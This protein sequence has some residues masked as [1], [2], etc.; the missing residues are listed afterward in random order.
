MRFHERLEDRVETDFQEKRFEPR[1][2]PNESIDP[3]W[4]GL[5][6]RVLRIEGEL[7]H[8]ENLLQEYRTTDV[9]LLQHKL[10]AVG[11]ELRDEINALKAM[12]IEAREADQ[13]EIH[14]KLEASVALQEA[15]RAENE[16]F[17][18]YVLDLLKEARASDLSVFQEQLSALEGRRIVATEMVE[19]KIK[20]WR[21][22]DKEALDKQ[23]QEYERRLQVLNG[24]HQRTAHVLANSISRE[25]FQSEKDAIIQS[26]TALDRTLLGMTPRVESDKAHTELALRFETA[27]AAAS[28]VLDTK[29]NVAQGQ[30]ADLKEYVDKTSGRNSGYSAV[31]GWGIAAVTILISIILM[32]NTFLGG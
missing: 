27:V 29:I 28:N 26:I 22:Y 6:E 18:T 14:L 20:V 16:K 12:R 9:Q 7:H 15:H 17:S 8:L 2:P 31:Y 30:I 3:V 19:E 5:K 1:Q 25:M 32:A 23:A 10:D 13:R 21:A 11:K 4:D 24:E